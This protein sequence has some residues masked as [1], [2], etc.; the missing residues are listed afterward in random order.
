MDRP[1]RIQASRW[2]RPVQCGPW[3]TIRPHLTSAPLS[4]QLR[5]QATETL[6][7]AYVDTRCGVVVTLTHAL[8]LVAERFASRPPRQK[9][10]AG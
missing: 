2:R 1:L 6:Q 7:E 5:L 8:G 3:K 9:G 4:N 10:N